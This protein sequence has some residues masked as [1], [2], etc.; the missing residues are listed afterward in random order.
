MAVSRTQW[1]G[2]RALWRCS[3]ITSARC[4]AATCGH[5]SSTTHRFLGSESPGRAKRQHASKP[6]IAKRYRKPVDLFERANT[7]LH[8]ELS[9]RTR[10]GHHTSKE[11]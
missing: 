1:T 11:A 9:D 6:E 4:G 10:S 7:R 5:Y 2:E 3:K 8:S